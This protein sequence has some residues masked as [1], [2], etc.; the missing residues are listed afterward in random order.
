VFVGGFLSPVSPSKDQQVARASAGRFLG[1]PLAPT[2]AA[3]IQLRLET[4]REKPKLGH[5]LNKF[6]VNRLAL[7]LVMHHQSDG[8]NDGGPG[9][10]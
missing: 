9:K 1:K 5:V 3:L 8:L 10:P 6:D 4:I 2:R 7:F